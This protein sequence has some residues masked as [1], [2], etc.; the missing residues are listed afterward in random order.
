MAKRKITWS[1][2]AYLQRKSILLYWLQR[3]KSNAYPKKLLTEIQKNTKQLSEFP[4]I[5]KPTDI[6]NVRVLAMD[7]YS[8]YY[9]HTKTKIQVVT[10]WDNRQ[11]PEILKNLLLLSQLGFEK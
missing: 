8:I 3:N 5:G 10:F 4:E 7:N 6:K 9:T 11:D 2:T 1:K